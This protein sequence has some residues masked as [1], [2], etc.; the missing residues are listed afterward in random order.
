MI[1]KS[2][3]WSQSILSGVHFSSQSV[4]QSPDFYANLRTRFV[5]RLGGKTAIVF[6]GKL[7]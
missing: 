4:S 7:P 3:S 1:N 6:L 5:G 2:L